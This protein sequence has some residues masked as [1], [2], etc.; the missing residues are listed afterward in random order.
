MEIREAKS[1]FASRVPFNMEAVLLPRPG[2]PA[3]WTGLH[4]IRKQFVL[5]V[6]IKYEIGMLG[7]TERRVFEKYQSVVVVVV[8]VN[9][10][11][12]IIHR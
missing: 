9:Y 12:I 11:S 6:S 7:W 10:S 5:R 4:A 8:V 3:A 2:P 1:F